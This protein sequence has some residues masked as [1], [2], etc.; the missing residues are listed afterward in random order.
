MKNSTKFIF[1]LASL[2]L[3]FSVYAE[4]VTTKIEFVEFM[5]VTMV[6]NPDSSVS[7]TEKIEYNFGE[8]EKH[9]IYRIIPLTNAVGTFDRLNIKDIGVTDENGISQNFSLSTN[10]P[11]SFNKV[12]NIK[13]GDPDITVSGKHTYIIKYTA[14]NLLGYFDDRTEVYWNVTGNEWEVPISYVEAHIIL[15]KSITESELKTAS[16]CGEFGSKDSCGDNTISYKNTELSTQ[17]D[18]SSTN[19]KDLKN[20]YLGQGITIAVGF[21]NGVVYTPSTS[22]IIIRFLKNYWFIPFPIFITLLWFRKSISYFIRRRKFYSK[23]TIIPEYDAGD[24]DPLEVAGILN[25]GIENKHLSAHIIYLAI[26]GYIIIKKVDDEYTFLGTKKDMSKLSGYS[27]NLLEGIADKTESDLTDTFDPI[28]TSIILRVMNSLHNREYIDMPVTPFGKPRSRMRGF[29][30]IFLSLFLAANPGVFIW[31]IVGKSAGFIFSGSCVLIGLVSFIVGISRNRLTNKGFEAEHKLL[32]LKHYISV[33]EEER[34]KFHN[35]P[36]KNPELFEKLLP[37]AMVFGLEKKWAKEFESIYTSV[38]NWYPDFSGQTFSTALF[39]SSL[40]DF[41]SSTTKSLFSSPLSFS[42][43][44][45]GSSGSSF[46]S[47]GSSSGSSGGGSSGGGGGGG[48][49]GS[50]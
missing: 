23:N 3:A 30:V 32:G 35:A 12:I 6:V 31:L 46:G 34:I 27:K 10:D 25:G 5:D 4:E 13:I 50:W 20:L 9:G 29:P 38:P 42:Y 2:L 47:S 1:L 49:G 11:L 44:G 21:P 24:M 17:V 22:D 43:G 18:F 15:P 37:Y 28:S 48:G 41:S 16:Y 33:A 7:V 8:E 39:A 36:E 45:R 40:N 19:E 14:Y 26:Q